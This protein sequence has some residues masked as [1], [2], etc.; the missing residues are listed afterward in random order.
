KSE[1]KYFNTA[2]IMDQALLLLLDNK[3]FEYITVKEIC[4]K[5]GVNRSTF[6]LHYET[7]ESL[8]KEFIENIADNYIKETD[9]LPLGRSHEEANRLFFEYFSKQEEY[10]QKILC[11]PPY[12]ELCN[13]IFD[14]AYYHA[15]NENHHYLK[16]S[17][18]KQ[19]IILTFYRSTTLDIYRQWIKDQKRMPLDEVIELSNQLICY[20]VNDI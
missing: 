13:T 8:I 10:V 15:L 3:P 11:Y 5:A 12:N 7:I 16:F 9:K 14:K 19:N 4:K 1:S 20:G 6:Y 17:K 18:E 2:S